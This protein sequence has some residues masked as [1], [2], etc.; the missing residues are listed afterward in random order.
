MNSSILFYIIIAILLIQ[1]IIETVLEYLNAK[2]YTDVVPSELSD[3]FDK[4][5]YRKSQEYKKPTIVLGW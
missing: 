5:E 3:V 1:F 4:E 2:R